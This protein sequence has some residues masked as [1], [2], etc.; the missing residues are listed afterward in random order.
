MHVLPAIC[1]ESSTV[2]SGLSSSAVSRS[3]QPTATLKRSTGT[4]PDLRPYHEMVRTTP[5]DILDM[6]IHGER[7]SVC[8]SL[9][10]PE[11]RGSDLRPG[12]SEVGLSVRQTRKITCRARS[13]CA[14]LGTLRARSC[15]TSKHATETAIGLRVRFTALVRLGQ[16]RSARSSLG[17]W[18]DGIS[19]S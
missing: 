16:S 7:G 13:L 17:G 8:S 4:Y 6:V 10:Y 11:L 1:L 14:T 9:A 3:W 18:P 19:D 15:P 2:M 5:S 12:L